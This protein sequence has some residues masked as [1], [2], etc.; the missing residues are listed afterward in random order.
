MEGALYGIIAEFA[1]PEQVLNAARGAYQAGYRKM[2]AYTPHEVEGLAEAL[3][4]H[5][6]R[7]SLVVL[8]G[9]IC[10]A[11][12]A[13]GMEWFSA[14][15]HFPL[16]VG[17][18]PLHSWPSFIPITF[19]LTVLFASLAA[20]FGML[21]MNGLP[22]PY[23]P[24]FNAPDFKLA[25]Q[26]RYFLCIEAEDPRFKPEEVRGFLQSYSPI[27]VVGVEV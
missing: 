8:I 13:Y 23:H 10:G 9:G 7:V 22:K 24:G 19:E 20:F 21:A 27:S 26:T 11:L 1:E 2:E 4:Y 14:A 16:N 6:T 12:T 3:G 5:K 25:T 18:R 17:G 15:I